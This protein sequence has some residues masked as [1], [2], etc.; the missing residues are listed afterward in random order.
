MAALSVL[1]FVLPK[2]TP[3]KRFLVANSISDIVK[4]FSGPIKIV[5]TAG[6]F[7]ASFIAF[8]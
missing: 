8:S 1:N 7:I 2:L 4:S 6:G 5:I 3:I